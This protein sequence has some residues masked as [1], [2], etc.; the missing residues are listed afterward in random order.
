MASWGTRNRVHPGPASSRSSD[1]ASGVTPLGLRVWSP[2]PLRVNG[3][4]RD[5][6]P[7]PT[8]PSILQELANSWREDSAHPS[9]SANFL[10]GLRR[11]GPGR[12]GSGLQRQNTRSQP[13]AAQVKGVGTLLGRAK[14]QSG[15]LLERVGKLKRASGNWCSSGGSC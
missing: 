8:S 10:Q 12:G 7:K 6:H 9:P 15:R 3:I 4:P 14:K 2:S 5:G 13:A 1:K 11:L